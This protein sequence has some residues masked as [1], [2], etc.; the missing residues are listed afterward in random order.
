MRWRREAICKAAAENLLRFNDVRTVMLA[1]RAMVY[2][3]ARMQVDGHFPRW[4]VPAAKA[5]AV[6]A[7]LIDLFIAAVAKPPRRRKRSNR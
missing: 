2:G 6:A 5:E 1:G 4:K 7:D 3:F